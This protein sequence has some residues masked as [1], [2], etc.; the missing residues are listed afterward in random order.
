[1]TAGAAAMPAN[2]PV[3][4]FAGAKTLKTR[5]SKVAAKRALPSRELPDGRYC[6]GPDGRANSRPK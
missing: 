2:R 3:S 4:S 1:L 5:P 6:M